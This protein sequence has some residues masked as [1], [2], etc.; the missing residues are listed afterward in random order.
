MIPNTMRTARQRA[1]GG[2]EVLTI[3]EVPV[4][5]PGPGEVLLRIHASDV[6]S[7]DARMRAFR[8]PGIFWLPGRLALGVFGPRN[9]V[10]GVD[11]AGE[12]VAIG[13]GVTRYSPGDRVFGQHGFF[14]SHA[15]Y[16]VVP[17]KAAMAAI[18]AGMS[19]TEAAALPFG[20][21]TVLDF[22]ARGNY[23][24]GESLLVNGASGAVGVA[25]VQIARAYGSPV[26][27]ICSAGN[28][29]TVR[30]LGAEAVLDYRS[31]GFALPNGAFDV[32]FDT[33]GNFRWATVATALKPTGRFWQAVISGGL[34][35]DSLRQG[36]RMLMGTGTPTVE[37]AL[38]LARLAAD[39]AFKPVIDSRFAFADIAEAHRRVDT[40][41]KVGAVV[42]EMQAGG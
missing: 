28:A 40:G 32:V 35:L 14:G 11:F 7:G 2:P 6:T 16:R 15:E 41:R 33:V 5:R 18:P 8:V 4:P 36:K 29:E 26:T 39:G 13:A 30:A 42:L 31:P 38:E 10:P 23:R 37:A 22:M 27:G 20:G 1:Y 25:A 21:F 24:K 9:Q 34:V 3:E 17:E 12:V 19:Y